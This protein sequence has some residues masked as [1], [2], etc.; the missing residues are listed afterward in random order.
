MPFPLW[1]EPLTAPG[2]TH[3]AIDSN[4]RNL[5]AAVAWA[6]SH[7]TEVT[8]ALTLALNPSPNRNPNPNPNQV[9]AMV[10]RANAAMDVA[11]SV[12]GIRRYVVR[13]RV[14]VSPDP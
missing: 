4:M 3:L 10:S 11:L 6:A 5:S 9:A 2:V 7:N 12:G 14:R 1:F 13:V 8:L